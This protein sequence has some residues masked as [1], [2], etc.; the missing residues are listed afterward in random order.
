MNAIEA[1]RTAALGGY[2]ARCENDK[3][4]HT[5]IAYCICRNRHC[6]KC[7]VWTAPA[8]QEQSDVSAN[9]FVQYCPG[10]ARSLI[11][12]CYGS[13]FRRLARQQLRHPGVLL[14]MGT[15]LLQDGERPDDQDA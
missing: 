7:H 4:A 12:Q 13:N 6:P 10:D 11:S 2:V 5:V 14:G 8:V 1:C 3:C 15:R 9:V